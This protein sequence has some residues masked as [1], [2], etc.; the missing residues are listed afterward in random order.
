MSY[1][2]TFKD[3]SHG[4]V[5]RPVP[6][7]YVDGNVLDY[8]AFTPELALALATELTG[9]D[10]TSAETLPY[11][12]NPRINRAAWPRSGVCPSFCFTPSVCAGRGSCPRRISCVD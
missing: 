2:I 8:S 9:K 4:C 5:E 3:G 7:G 1:W 10:A 11:P 6:D 12:A